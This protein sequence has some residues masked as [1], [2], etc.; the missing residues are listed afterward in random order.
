MLRTDALEFLYL[1]KGIAPPFHAGVSFALEHKALNKDTWAEILSAFLNQK[2]INKDCME[3]FRRLY[4][5]RVTS[6][7]DDI[8]GLN[9]AD[10][11]K[12]LIEQAQEVRDR[13][14]RILGHRDNQAF[15]GR[16]F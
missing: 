11:E 14:L 5:I 12:L 9:N 3:L 6:F 2:D 4:E 8:E 15:D 1:H 16:C 13:Y 10:T 7:W